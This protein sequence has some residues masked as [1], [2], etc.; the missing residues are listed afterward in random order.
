MKRI[1]Q[2]SFWKEKTGK[3]GFFE[4]PSFQSNRD[5][6]SRTRNQKIIGAKYAFKI[7]FA[8]GIFVLGTTLVL[9]PR[10]QSA[11]ETSDPVLLSV[12]QVRISQNLN[13]LK[14]NPELEIAALA[15][16]RDIINQD[17]FD[18][19]SPS[20]LTPWTLIETAGYNYQKAGEN[21]AIDFNTTNEAF[22]AWMESASHR[23]N[24]LNPNFKETGIA[25]L[26]GEFNDRQ[27]LVIVQLFGKAQNPLE[28]AF[29]ALA[30]D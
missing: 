13:P 5:K 27:T 9:L 16:A 2:T 24:I 17:Y 1:P 21:L 20:G 11:P 22:R 4:P 3:G 30:F 15:K 8:V 23:Q 29:E 26:V 12:N 7:I 10:T 14:I 18:H 28:K 19:Q 25:Y 6:A